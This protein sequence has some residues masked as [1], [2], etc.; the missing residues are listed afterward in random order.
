MIPGMDP[1]QMMR[2]MQ[3]M[4]IKTKQVVAKRVVIEQEDGSKLVVSS[5]QVV[6]IEMQGQTSFQ[7]MG[8]VGEEA[9]GPSVEDIQMVVEQTGASKE[10]AV[11]A[12]K[13]TNDIAEAI[14]KLKKE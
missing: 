5:P 9:S 12:L 2:M 6:Q 8:S 7:I 13:E 14:L 3:Q 1:K 11:A 10:E 4:G